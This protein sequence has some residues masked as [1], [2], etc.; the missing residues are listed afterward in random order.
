MQPH[1]LSCFP[2]L[3]PT[4]QVSVPV[5]FNG[6]SGVQVRN[7]PN[8]AD[9]ASYTSLKFYITLPEAARKRRQD[10]NIKQFVFYLGNKDV[11]IAM[12]SRKLSLLFVAFYCL[13]II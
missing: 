4:P 7:P 10:D 2:L 9:L 3:T 12:A 5:K 1:S 8:L 6:A 11:S 13:L